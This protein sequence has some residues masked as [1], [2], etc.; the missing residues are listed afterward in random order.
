MKLIRLEPFSPESCSAFLTQGP[1]LGLFSGLTANSRSPIVYSPQA[2][3]E[4]ADHVIMR[5]T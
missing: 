5:Q 3:S 4:L 1:L 2:L